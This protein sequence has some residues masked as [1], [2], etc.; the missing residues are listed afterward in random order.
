MK[1]MDARIQR[2]IKQLDEDLNDLLN[3]LKNYSADQLNAQPEPGAWS[4]FQVMQHLMIA[5]SKSIGYVK[6][7]TSYPEG[8]KKAGFPE[9]F[10]RKVLKLFL[11][12]PFKY[13][14]PAIVNETHFKDK[15]TLDELANTW[16]TSRGELAHFLENMKPEWADKEIFRHAIAGRMTLD[17]MLIFFSDHFARH[18]KQIDRTLQKVATPA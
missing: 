4:V 6:K 17:G 7:K 5:E 12:L 10:R 2:Q 13:K 11:W 8:L 9:I 1:Y 14:A 18:R 15:V 16:R 3:D